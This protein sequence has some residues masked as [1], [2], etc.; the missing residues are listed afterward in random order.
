MRLDIWMP[1]CSWCSPGAVYIPGGK[2]QYSAQLAPHWASKSGRLGHLK[3]SVY[4]LKCEVTIVIVC[5]SV[6][7]TGDFCVYC[8]VCTTDSGGIPV[9]L[10][11]VVNARHW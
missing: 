2:L 7:C 6:S 10:L 4:G 1:G 3:L 11:L 8:T 5:Q 9:C